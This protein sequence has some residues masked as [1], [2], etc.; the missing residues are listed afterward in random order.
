M[1]LLGG[2]DAGA[3]DEAERLFAAGERDPQKLVAAMRA[4]LAQAPAAKIDYVEIVDDETLQ[5][6]AGPISRPALAALAVWIG[7]PRLIDNTVLVP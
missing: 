3:L 4:L 5:P 6:L 1:G 7:K 2:L